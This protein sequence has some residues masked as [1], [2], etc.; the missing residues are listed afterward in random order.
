MSG[1]PPPPPQ[2]SQLSVQDWIWTFLWPIGG[3]GAGALSLYELWS[4]RFH[5]FGPLIGLGLS[6]VGILT[7]RATK[8]ASRGI[9]GVLAVTGV[10]LNLLAGVLEIVAVTR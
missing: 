8:G 5:V 1:Q 2:A 10:A 4:G 6:G 9:L 7:W 3:G